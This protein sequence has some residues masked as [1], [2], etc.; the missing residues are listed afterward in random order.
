VDNPVDNFF[1][2]GYMFPIVGYLYEGK[3]EFP[4]KSPESNEKYVDI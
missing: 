1:L 2:W 3:Q 4:D